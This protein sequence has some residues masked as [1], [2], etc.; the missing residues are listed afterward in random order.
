MFPALVVH[1]YQTIKNFRGKKRTI[2]FTTFDNCH[3]VNL[4][5]EAVIDSR[6]SGNVIS[7]L[8]GLDQI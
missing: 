5:V 3:Y 7:A 1:F 8:A 4:E 2:I 6:R